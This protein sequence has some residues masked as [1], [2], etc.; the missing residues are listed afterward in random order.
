MVVFDFF[1]GGPDAIIYKH[2]L[3]ISMGQKASQ[4]LHVQLE[5]YIRG[6]T[7]LRFSHV[8]LKRLHRI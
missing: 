3:I 1:A 4:T 5:P 2:N 6:K 7:T 8:Y